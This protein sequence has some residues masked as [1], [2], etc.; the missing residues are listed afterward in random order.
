MSFLDW[1]QE[2][3]FRTRTP[4]SAPSRFIPGTFAYWCQR[5][6][7]AVSTYQQAAATCPRC[8]GQLLFLPSALAAPPPPPRAARLEFAARRHKGSDGKPENTTAFLTEFR[9]PRDAA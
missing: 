6:F 9:G 3:I 1:M 5:C 7:G 4:Q 2:Q 8:G